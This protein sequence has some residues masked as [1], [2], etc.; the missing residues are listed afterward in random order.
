MFLILLLIL[1]CRQ[2]AK[3]RLGVYYTM[4]SVLF[5]HTEQ[6]NCTVTKNWN[7]SSFLPFI[8]VSWYPKRRAEGQTVYASFHVPAPQLWA[9]AECLELHFSHGLQ[10]LKC[11]DRVMKTCANHGLSY[12]S[13]HH[14]SFHV[15]H[16]YPSLQMNVRYPNNRLTA[17]RMGFV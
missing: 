13:S 2:T 3:N 8:S 16:N 6:Q 7:I 1:C 14:E 11:S 9:V 12:S 17:S 5:K 10:Q 15:L 4:G